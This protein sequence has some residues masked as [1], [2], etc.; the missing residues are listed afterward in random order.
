MV[1]LKPDDPI[2]SEGPQVFVP[3]PRPAKPQPLLG[4]PPTD[5]DMTE[6]YSV[7]RQL[8]A[9]ERAVAASRKQRNRD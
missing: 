5:E 2:F 7:Q 6:Q 4:S 1:E 3:A 9:I 8:E